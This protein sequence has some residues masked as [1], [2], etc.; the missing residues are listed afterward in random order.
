L[1]GKSLTADRI[2][3]YDALVPSAR[4]A[5][6]PVREISKIIPREDIYSSAPRD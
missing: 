3:L 4:E 2:A 1:A 6:R 5:K